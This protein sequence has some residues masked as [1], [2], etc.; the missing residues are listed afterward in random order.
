MDIFKVTNS[1][2]HREFHYKILNQILTTNVT[3]SKYT[4]GITGTCYFCEA[5][6]ET[7]AHLLWRL[8]ENQGHVAQIEKLVQLF[9]ADEVKPIKGNNHLQ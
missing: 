8:S 5:Y 6:K 2:K 4:L 1:I 3:R 7:A 9:H